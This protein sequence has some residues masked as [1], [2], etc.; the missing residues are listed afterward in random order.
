[1]EPLGRVIPR[2]WSFP[3]WEKRLKA[4]RVLGRWAEIVG[5]AVA[6]ATRP[7]AFSQGRLWVEVEDSVWMTR[8]RFEERR[9]LK[10]LNEAAGER[11]FTSIR[12]VLARRP[13]PQ[14]A[15]ARPRG[16]FELPKDWQE[17]AQKEVAHIEDPEL[18]EAF[19]RLRLTLL[20]K[21]TRPRPL[22]HKAPLAADK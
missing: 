5:P 20:A 11:L 17:K 12:W 7:R 14:R 18:R 15:K 4:G 16:P 3:G 22:G 2:L 19:L 21:R 1:M 8:L 10:L 13:W 9:L 6:R